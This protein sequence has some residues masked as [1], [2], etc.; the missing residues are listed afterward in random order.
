[1]AEIPSAAPI[2]N[3][4]VNPKVGKSINSEVKFPA[5]NESNII[6]IINIA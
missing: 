6:S 1:M 3:G 4:F 5:Y 2:N